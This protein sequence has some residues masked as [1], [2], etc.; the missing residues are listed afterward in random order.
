[1][2]VGNP[3]LRCTEQ[4]AAELENNARLRTVDWLICI[5]SIDLL[6][7]ALHMLQVV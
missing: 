2:P 1:M 6:I 7:D 4:F 3:G 5:S